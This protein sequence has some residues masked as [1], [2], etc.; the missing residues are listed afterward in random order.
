AFGSSQVPPPP[1]PPP[2]TNQEE[3]AWSIPSS[4]VPILK[5]NWASALTSSYSPPPEDSLL[6]YT[7]EGDCR[8][9]AVTFRDKYGVQMI[10]RFNEIHKFSDGTLHQIDEALDY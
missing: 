5:N 6:T 2:S 7:S 8:A 4:D 3:P 10:M 1:P 9:G